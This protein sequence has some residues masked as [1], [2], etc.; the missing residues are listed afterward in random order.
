[1]MVKRL[2]EG[3][4]SAGRNRPFV[5]KR[6]GREWNGCMMQAEESTSESLEE[7]EAGYSLWNS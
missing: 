5:I 7:V 1:M 3:S 2:W 4:K 6:G